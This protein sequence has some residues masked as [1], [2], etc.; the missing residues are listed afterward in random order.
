MIPILGLAD[1]HLPAHC[2]LFAL[3]RMPDPQADA[4]LAVMY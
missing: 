2:P 3:T 4:D 1:F